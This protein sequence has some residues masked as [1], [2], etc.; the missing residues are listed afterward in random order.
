[1][2]KLPIFDHGLTPLEKFEFLRRFKNTFL[3]HGKP[4]FFYLQYQRTIFLSFFAQKKSRENF[5]IFYQIMPSGKIGICSLSKQYIF[6][7]K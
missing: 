3:L 2:E 4:F 5:Q 1:M 7:V 6:M